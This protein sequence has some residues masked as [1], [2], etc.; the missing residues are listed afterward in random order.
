MTSLIDPLKRRWLRGNLPKEQSLR[1]P[2]AVSEDNFINGCTQ[3]Q[4][5]IEACET[6]IIVRDGAGFPKVDLSRGECTFCQKCIQ[7]CQEPLFTIA[8]YTNTQ[9]KTN[10]RPWPITININEKCLAKN[11]IYCQSCR[12]ECEAQAINFSY[13]VN[14]MP[15]KIPQP[16]INNDDCSQCGACISTCPQ[17]AIILNFK[18]DSHLDITT[19]VEVINVD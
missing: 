6:N 19:K 13:H 9:Q 4:S 15:S 5:C 11:N 3:C 14:G 17:N 16:S 7:A 12:D 2:W 10:A 8:Q 1:L 18:Q